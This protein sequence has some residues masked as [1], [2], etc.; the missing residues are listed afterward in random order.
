MHFPER[1]DTED[2]N[3]D[4]AAAAAAA[5]SHFWP[6]RQLVA[7]YMAGTRMGVP[8]ATVVFFSR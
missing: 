6:S 7:S 8:K 5:S 2:G 1:E 4:D 3:E